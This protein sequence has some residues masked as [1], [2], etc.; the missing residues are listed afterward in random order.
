MKRR[1]E[2]GRRGKI[3]R[4]QGT[5]AGNDTSRRVLKAA[6]ICGPERAPRPAAKTRSGEDAASHAEDATNTAA[7]KRSGQDRS[8]PKGSAHTRLVNGAR[9]TFIQLTAHMRLVDGA[10]A[11]DR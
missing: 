3:G 9:R 7:K 5:K 1:R 4:R 8:K 6:K 10:H 2:T 11:S